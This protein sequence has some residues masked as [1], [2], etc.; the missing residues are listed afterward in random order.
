MLLGA[1]P[2][3][4]ELLLKVALWVGHDVLKFVCFFCCFVL[5]RDDTGGGKR[6]RRC[7]SDLNV[8]W[9]V[10]WCGLWRCSLVGG[11]VTVCCRAFVL[12]HVPGAL[13]FAVGQSDDKTCSRCHP[14]HARPA[15]VDSQSVSLDVVCFN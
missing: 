10:V 14:K 11:H 2:H 6:E 5:M 15:K 12:F 1:D 8:L 7:L 3:A 9:V 4:G 13:F